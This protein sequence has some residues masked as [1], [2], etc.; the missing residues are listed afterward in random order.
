M[1]GYMMDCYEKYDELIAAPNLNWVIII[2]AD[3]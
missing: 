2:T 3:D 1:V